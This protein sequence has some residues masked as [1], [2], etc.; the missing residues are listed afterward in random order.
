MLTLC[1]FHP[2]V[3]LDR[4]SLRRAHGVLQARSSSSPLLDPVR[5][6][7]SLTTLIDARVFQGLGGAM[8]VP[9]GRHSAPTLRAEERPRQR[10]GLS[11]HAGAY[12]AGQQVRRLGGFITTYFHWRWIFWINVPIGILGRVAVAQVH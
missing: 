8:M 3:R 11:D 6:F 4:R 5:R 7:V 10:D 12:R 9:V 2:R 1:G